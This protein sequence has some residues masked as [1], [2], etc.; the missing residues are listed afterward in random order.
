MA[1]KKKIYSFDDLTNPI[2]NNNMG[3]RATFY[4]RD[5]YKSVGESREGIDMWYDDVHYGRVDAN[6]IP[7]YPL[8]STLVQLKTLKATVFAINFVAAA[9]EDFREF[10]NSNP[11]S[12]KS[13]S[14]YAALDPHSG[15]KSVHSTY[16][17]MNAGMF[18]V[19][20]GEFM[21]QARDQK[22]VN[23]KGFVEV[24]MEFVN[25]MAHLLPITR[26]SMITSRYCPPHISCLIIEIANGPYGNDSVKARFL[27]DVNYNYIEAAAKRFG[28]KIDKNAPW[29]FVADLESEK[30]QEY[31]KRYITTSDVFDTMYFKSHETE[32][33]I[34]KDY[35]WG[36]Y[37]QFIS[38]SPTANKVIASRCSK[39][40]FF[41]LIRRE[42][43]SKRELFYKYSDDYW[44]RLYILVRAR[45]MRKDW[46]QKKFDRVV[47]TVLDYKRIRG[48]DTAMLYLHREL[49]KGRKKPLTSGQSNGMMGRD[50]TAGSTGSFNY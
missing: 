1:N 32:L 50:N 21:N 44:T 10:V 47:K 43:V 16:H 40:T 30:M 7:V 37:N 17:E 42:V 45:E 34:F 2:G 24:Y 23:F 5:I 27:N 13:G 19:F 38:E 14:V 33:N 15:W 9:W 25:S 20:A 36:W 49:M 31:R 28:F 41:E 26:E 8:E 35:M 6:G 11:P 29:R 48:T 4:W 46:T 12:T 39:S 3:S 18:E 22:I